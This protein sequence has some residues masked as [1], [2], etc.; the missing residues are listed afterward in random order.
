MYRKSENFKAIAFALIAIIILILPISLAKS[1]YN[2]SI[3]KSEI[4]EEYEEQMQKYESEIR[5]LEEKLEETTS[6]ANI[7]EDENFRLKDENKELW[8][9]LDE[10]YMKHGYY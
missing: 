5:Y 2:K 1:F 8:D 4:I 3:T 10:L 9:L 6:K 7:Y